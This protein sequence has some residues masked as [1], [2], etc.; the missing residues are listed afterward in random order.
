MGNSSPS[1]SIT[2]TSYG[3]SKTRM[4]VAAGVFGALSILLTILSQALVLSFPLIPYLQFDFGEVAILL[5]FFLFGPIPATASAIVE[6]LVLMEFGQNVPVGP[7]LKIVAIL[8]SLLGLW[9]GIKVVPSKLARSSKGTIF[10]SSLVF[11]LIFRAGAMTV[12]NYILIVYFYGVNAILGFV[13]ALF[14][15]I[16]ITITNSNGL[17]VVLG[18]TAIF[19]CLQLLMVFLIAYAIMRLPQFKVLTRSSRT[20]WFESVGSQPKES[21][22]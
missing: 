12:A 17:E 15:T 20:A 14:K 21:V 7:V 1:E 22:N 19:N 9:L 10:A 18:F 13:S 11:G 3:I 16:G 6:F 5:A 2:K 4:I 8:S